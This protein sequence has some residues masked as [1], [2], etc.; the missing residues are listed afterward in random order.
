[1]VVE[2]KLALALPLPRARHTMSD[3]TDVSKN[4]LGLMHGNRCPGEIALG[5]REME[6]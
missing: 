6:R 4:S 1:M 5:S 3:F 2:E